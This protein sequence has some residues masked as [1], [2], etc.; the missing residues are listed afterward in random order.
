MKLWRNKWFILVSIVS[1]FFMATSARV[2]LA[3]TD[4]QLDKI[5]KAGTD[6][7]IEYFAWLIEVLKLIW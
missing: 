2:V 6:G 4:L 3:G 1:L 7:L 5:L